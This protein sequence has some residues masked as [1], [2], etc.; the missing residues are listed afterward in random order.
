MEKILFFVFILWILFF[1]LPTPCNQSHVESFDNPSPTTNTT[2]QP[3]ITTIECKDQ[4]T[5]YIENSRKY[6]KIVTSILDQRN[7]NSPSLYHLVLLPT[8]HLY[9]PSFNHLC[10]KY[11]P[12]LMHQADINIL[13]HYMSKANKVGNTIPVLNQCKEENKIIFMNT[14]EIENVTEGRIFGFP[15]NSTLKYALHLEL[16]E[17][18]TL[19][20][21]H[22]ICGNLISNKSD[23]QGIRFELL[24]NGQIYIPVTSQYISLR[25]IPETINIQNET[26][27]FDNWDPIHKSL[28]LQPDGKYLMKG[29]LLQLTKNIDNAIKFNF[30]S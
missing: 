20:V 6:T 23:K 26:F 3:S 21:Y 15:F 1:L 27:D 2:I 14:F 10:T 25:T 16:N 11:I 29:F 12:M 24:N 22:S 30:I 7:E 18:S 17:T 19:S 28:Y 4:E 13:W 9:L 5:I 8:E